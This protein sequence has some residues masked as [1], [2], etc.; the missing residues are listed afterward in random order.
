[1]IVEN[2]STFMKAALFALLAAAPVFAT[3]FPPVDDWKAAV[4]AGDQATLAKLYSRNPEAFAQMVK[5]R[6]A[7]K[8]EWAYWSALK[9]NGMTE[10]TPRV[11]EFTNVDGKTRVLLRISAASG[12]M[13]LVAGVQQVW[14]HQADGWKIIA[15]ARDEFAVE[16]ARRLP[17]PAAPNTNLYAEPPEAEKELHEGLARAAKEHKRVIVVF[18]GNWCYDCHVLDTTFHS[19]EFAPLVDANYVVVHINV[20]DEGKDNA[21]LGKRLGV[22]LDKGVPSLGVLEADGKVIYAQKN[23]EFEST[24]RIGPEDV[25]AFLLKWKLR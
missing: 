4:I 18:G 14:A 19:K 25:R 15:S 9:R 10:F 16:E 12:N 8:D 5:T 2:E 23:G 17:Q 24:V 3:V 21:E 6:V 22:A 7:L 11:L 1:M 20:G 13:R